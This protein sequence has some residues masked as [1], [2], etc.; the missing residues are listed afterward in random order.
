M[1]GHDS[2]VKMQLHWKTR[3]LQLFAMDLAECRGFLGILVSCH[4]YFLRKVVC[5]ILKETPTI[6]L[7]HIQE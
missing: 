2:S 3:R 7:V 5:T 6:L 4:I 1:A